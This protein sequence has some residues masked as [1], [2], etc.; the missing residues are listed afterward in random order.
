MR[1]GELTLVETAARL[2]S[3]KGWF[4]GG[5]SMSTF[6]DKGS[7]SLRKMNTVLAMNREEGT[8]TCS[9]DPAIDAW[10]CFHRS[11]IYRTFA[12]LCISS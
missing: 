6:G 12:A 11:A 1:Q 10:Y 7:S 2:L 4:E 3:E 5:M 9:S 8:R